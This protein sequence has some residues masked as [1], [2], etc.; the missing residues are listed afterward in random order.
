MDK[1]VPL[2]KEVR[3]FAETMGYD[4]SKIEIIKEKPTAFYNKATKM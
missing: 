4:K 2:K 3:E 1:P